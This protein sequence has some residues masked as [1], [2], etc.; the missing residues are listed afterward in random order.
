MKRV[1][2]ITYHFAQNYGAVLQCYAL[3]KYLMDNGY[4]VTVFN[5]LS[6]KQMEN[7]DIKM[8]SFQIKSIIKN[9]CLIPFRKY[10]KIKHDRFQMFR[11]EYLNLTPR[12]SNIEDLRFF[13]ESNNF[14][15]IISGSDQVLNS[16]IADFDLA[17]LYPFKTK[18]KKFTYAA[19]T[20]N[21]TVYDIKEL[22]RY[23]NDFNALSL[24]EGKDIVKFN[25]NIKEKISI[26]C[27]PVML[28]NKKVWEELTVKSIYTPYLVCYF[29]HKNLYD[30]E[31]KYAKKIASELGLKLKI[32]NARFSMKS[33]LEES[34][35][36]VGP[37]EFINLIANANYICT[38][39][40][41]GTLFSLIFHKKFSCFDTLKNNNDNRKRDILERVGA[42]DTFQNV[43][44]PIKI[45]R[46][47]DYQI[48]DK[49]IDKIKEESKRFLSNLN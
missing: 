45:C 32:I 13:I 33:F 18:A 14:D 17:F 12:F 3:S 48:I 35:L 43:E 9:I 8:H 49:N 4:D 44:E 25:D 36:D 22:N 29:L 34:V 7:N 2:I 28:V 16:N 24:R 5:F 27:D 38:D 19:S 15:Y 46:N 39:S 6:E 20:G 21:A 42:I 23:L 37:K 11:E 31:F 41:H 30:S 10:I 40:F 47:L 26:V 1:G